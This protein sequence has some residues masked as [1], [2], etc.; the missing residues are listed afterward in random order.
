MSQAGPGHLHIETSS[1]PAKGRRLQ[2]HPC[3]D[4]PAEAGE[5]SWRGEQSCLL[6]HLTLPMTLWA[7]LPLALLHPGG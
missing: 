3:M 4:G 6:P 2:P 1:D 5:E 7:L